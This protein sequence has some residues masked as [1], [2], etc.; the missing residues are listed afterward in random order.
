MKTKM[1]LKTLGLAAVMAASSGAF[2][3]GWNDD[4]PRFG[5]PGNNHGSAFR[6]SLALIKNVNERQDNQHERITQSYREGRLTQPEFRKLM[7]EQTDIRKMERSFMADGILSR[8]E[9]Q[10]LDNALDAASKH[11]FVEAHDANGKP[12][13][14]YGYGKPYNG[15]APWNR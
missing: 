12:V 1:I 13:Y 15:P 11:I 10:K 5:F 14:G 4:G 3:H 6:E 8:F 2:A 9:F 7:D